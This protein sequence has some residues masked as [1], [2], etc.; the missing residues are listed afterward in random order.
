MNSRIQRLLAPLGNDQDPAMRRPWSRVVMFKNVGG[1]P[2]VNRPPGDFPWNRGF[3][4][5]CLDQAGQPTHICKCRDESDDLARTETTLLERLSGE[6]GLASW[7]PATRSVRDD[8]LQIQVSVYHPHRSLADLL[9]GMRETEWR[10]TTRRILEGSHLVSLRSAE[11]LP[12]FAGRQTRVTFT[13]AARETLGYAR[14]ERLID[15]RIAGQ[16]A[17]LFDGAGMIVPHPQHGDLWPG[18]VLV[19]AD[20]YRLVDFET[21]GR[22]QVPL[23]DVFHLIRSSRDCRRPPAAGDNWGSLIASDAEFARMLGALVP[24]LARL[25]GMDREQIYPAFIYYLIELAVWF[26]RRLKDHPYAR[27]F[28]AE[29]GQLPRL[30]EDR[31]DARHTLLGSGQ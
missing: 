13:D 21:F 20:G 28:L 2:P 9:P 17:T 14:A 11:V 1:I 15:E 16:L 27:P 25:Q 12:Q 29:L 5:F 30:L 31:N 23:F 8:R 26:H 6:P 3:D 22:V 10:D 7:L 24:E 4:L 18:N 19:V